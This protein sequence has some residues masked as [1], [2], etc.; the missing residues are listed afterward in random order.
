MRCP[1]LCRIYKEDKTALDVLCRYVLE[2]RMDAVNHDKN[3]F[4]KGRLL[5]FLDLNVEKGWMNKNTGRS[6]KAASNKVLEDLPED[7]TLSGVDVRSAVLRYH[8]RHPGDLSPES[9]RI[10][11]RRVKQAIEAFKSW[12]E[13]PT[14]YKPTT[15][16]VT[17]VETP[18]KPRVELAGSGKAAST[19]TAALSTG[20]AQGASGASAQ[21]LVDRRQL[22]GELTESSLVMPFPLRPNFLAQIVV[23]RDMTNEEGKRLCQF[24]MALATWNPERS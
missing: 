7:D 1:V 13:D 22:A 15:K 9:L 24:V 12:V 6:W 17:R 11:E 16:D 20:S 4:T 19:A 3:P 5:A 14:T 8:N 10:Y 21:P 18:R 23:P 2:S